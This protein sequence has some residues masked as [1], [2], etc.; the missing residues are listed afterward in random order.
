MYLLRVPDVQSGRGER[1]LLF[2]VRHGYIGRQVDGNVGVYG[3]QSHLAVP[4]RRQLSGRSSASQT[5]HAAHPRRGAGAHN[6]Q[7]LQQHNNK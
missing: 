6:R 5:V 7:H 2:A 1:V 3:M 4:R